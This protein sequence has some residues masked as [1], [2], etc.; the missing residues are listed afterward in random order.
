M[1]FPLP[2][3]NKLFPP[4]GVPLSVTLLL[5]RGVTGVARGQLRQAMGRPPGHPTTAAAVV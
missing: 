3:I 5:L 4:Q 2:M 1:L